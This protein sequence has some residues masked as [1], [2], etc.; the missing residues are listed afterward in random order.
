MP[1]FKLLIKKLYTMYKVNNKEY[2]L[3][4]FLLVEPYV[5]ELILEMNKI[6]MQFNLK[7]FQGNSKINMTLV[8]Q[9]NT[10]SIICL[11]KLKS[12][13][14]I[15]SVVIEGN[16]ISGKET[17]SRFLFNDLSRVA[18]N[19]RINHNIK[20]DIYLLSFPTYTSQIGIEIRKLLK[21]SRKTNFDKYLLNWLFCYD[22]INTMFNMYEMFNSRQL[23][24]KYHHVIVFDRFYQSN[25]IYNKEYEDDPIVDWLLRTESVFF[26]STNIKDIIIFH[27]DKTE[28]DRIHNKLIMGKPDKDLNETIEFQQIIRD[29]FLS[30]KFKYKVSKEYFKPNNINISFF[31]VKDVVVDE[32][33][34]EESFLN[35]LYKN[36]NL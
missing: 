13:I 36:L 9:I 2:N 4:D 32:L 14:S 7:S 33:P 30:H 25:W 35:K 24:G 22:R 21:K 8:D 15:D 27:R 34:K 18:N 26:E 16:D 29:R 20:H 17:Y 28:P 5:K 6:E 11:P 10:D 12:H 1:N 23:F 19:T 3:D 31:T